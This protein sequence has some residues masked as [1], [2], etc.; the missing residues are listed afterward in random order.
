AHLARTTGMRGSDTVEPY[1]DRVRRAVL[2]HMPASS[3]AGHHRRLALAHE[4]TGQ[5]DAEAL[6][7]H[8]RDAGDHDKAAH[9][10][11]VAANKAAKALAFDRAVRLY[12]Q[13][14]LLS[15]ERTSREVR[16][17]LA[18]ALANAGRGGES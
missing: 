9:Y 12:E 8:W 2:G 6:A 11:Q 5:H 15:G 16:V 18:E 3:L 17:R 7:V 4:M 1:H 14:L 13:C 10:S